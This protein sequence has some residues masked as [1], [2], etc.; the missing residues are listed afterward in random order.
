MAQV[1]DAL[2]VVHAAGITHRD[3]KPSNLLLTRR[4]DGALLAKLADFGLGAA[5]DEDLLK[6]VSASRSDGL[7]GTSDY[8]APERRAGAPA[9]PQSDLYALGLTLYQIVVGRRHACA[10]H[11]LG[12]APPRRG[13]ARGRAPVDR[14]RPRG[15]LA[16]GGRPREGAP[17][18]RRAP[19]AA[20]AR[21]GARRRRRAR[22]AR[23][24]RLVAGVGLGAVVL[25]ALGGVAVWKW[26]E[27]DGHRA[28]AERQRDLAREQK[29]LALEGIA[30]LTHDVPQRLRDVP[31]ALPVVR[32]VVAGNLAMLDRVLALEPDIAGG[33]PREAL[34]PRRP[35]ATPGG[36][37]ATRRRPPR[38]SRPRPRLAVATRRRGAGRSR[39][40]LEP[41]ARPR[42]ARRRACPAGAQA[43]TS[44]AR[45]RAEPRAHAHGLVGVG[46]RGARRAR[47]PGRGAR[48]GRRARTWRSAGR[49]RP[50]RRSAEAMALEEA[51][52]KAAPDDADAMRSLGVRHERMGD[53]VIVAR[54]A[55]RGAAPLRGRAMAIGER[56][57]ARWPDRPGAPPRPERRATTSSAAPYQALG[58]TEE[59]LPRY[60]ASLAIAERLAAADPENVELAAR[61]RRGPRSPGRPPPRRGQDG[62]GARGVREGHGDRRAPG[63]RRPDER[64]R[65]ARPLRRAG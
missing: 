45:V 13:R 31:G 19:R 47:R 42:A 51:R 23:M 7:V 50:R 28:E 27:A 49:R 38:R 2:D 12:G 57:A 36:S 58:R 64:P 10:A 32:D 41:H 29:Q 4:G 63:G 53:L 59:A 34:E 14:P 55:R 24:R 6:S 20:R 61:R 60:E 5:E 3:V 15:P 54:A 17:R 48:Q 33:A 25:L 18:P 35:R 44:L 30:R 62:G 56:L 1:A 22:R 9:T 37:S 11:R 43:T 40:R 8:V 21:A 39:G 16:P 26:R 52:V 65:A 46:P